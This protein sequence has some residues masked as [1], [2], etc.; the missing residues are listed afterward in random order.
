MNRIRIVIAL[1]VITL[2]SSV[3]AAG[4]RVHAQTPA[5]ITPATVQATATTLTLTPLG[6]AMINSNAPATNFGGQAEL[7]V[8]KVGNTLQPEARSLLRFDLTAIPAGSTIQRA[9]LRLHQIR[10]TGGNWTM[11]LARVSADWNANTVTW[12]TR[13]PVGAF[14]DYTFDAPPGDDIVLTVDVTNLVE[15][16]VYTPGSMPN[17]GFELSG[18]T[19]IGAS[20]T[21]A[22]ASMEGK[23]KPELVIDYSAPPPAVTILE[24]TTPVK[25]DANCLREEYTNAATLNYVDAFAQVSTIFLKHDAANIYVCIQG[26]AGRSA[27]RFFGVYLD[28]DFGREEYA[29]PEDLAL[30]VGITTNAL[31]SYQ[32]TG[33]QDI[34]YTPVELPLGAWEAT[35]MST[36]ADVAEYRIARSLIAPG[37]SNPFGLAVYHQRVND[38]SDDYGLPPGQQAFNTP[39]AW[40]QATLQNPRCVRVCVETSVPCVPA[41]SATV[42][43]T[44]NGAAFSLDSNG[45]VIGGQQLANGDSL[46]A[47]LPI[48]SGAN[49]TLYHTSGEPVLVSAEAF[50][51]STAGTLTLVVTRQKPL[52]V[53]DL[54]VSAEWYV[55]G[56]P[57]RE[58]W[59]REN[60]IKAANYFYAFT[61]GQFA[62][63]QITVH[64]SL[65]AWQAADLRLHINNVL[66]P[67]AIIG[68]IVPTTTID[69]W[70]VVSYTYSPGHFFMGSHWN[71]YGAPPN[72]PIK[73]NGEPVPPA[74]MADDWALAMAHE[75]G[76][77]LLFLFD[78]YTDV[79]GNASQ[80]LAAL[81]TGSAM[82]DVYK[83]GNQNY[84]YNLSHWNA[85]C[86][87]TEA[88]NKL[89]GRSEWQTIQAWYPWAIQP[90]GF[91]TGP[92]AP[93]INLTTVNF[94][95]PSTAP[96][97]L[98]TS[99]VFD[100]LYQAGELTSGEARV[101]TLRG[102]RVY[103]QGKPAK[104]DTQVTLIDAQVADRLCVYDVNDQAEAGDAPRHQFGCEIIQLNDAELMMTK[105]PT[106]EPLIKLTQ[107]GPNQV[108]LVVTNP[109]T[110]PVGAQVMARL[111]PEH[112]LGY[113]PLALTGSDGVYSGVFDLPEP[114]P[115]LYAQLWVEETPAGL[116]TRREVMADRGTGG[117]GAFGPATRFGGVLVVSSD[118]NA[119]YER[120]Q[121]LDLGLGQSI[122]WQSMPG[123][124][125]LPSGNQIIGQSYRLDAYPPSL[126][127]S[128]KVHIQYRELTGLAQAAGIKQ[129]RAGDPTVYF[130][131][132][133]VWRPLGTIIS[134]PTNAADGVQLA[135]AQSQGVGVYIVMVDPGQH[136]IFLPVVQRK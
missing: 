8:S 133:N 23:I 94:V 100:L 1:L 68:G 32:G 64:Q 131:D 2:V 33:N 83:P 21:R 118:G 19:V 116:A 70:A 97:T 135:T 128:G 29:E 115:P 10:A 53:Y 36:N 42:F 4:T 12:N 120:D 123:T 15:R 109:L 35:A 39:V 16:W 89:K 65:D 134:T 88:H 114:V 105:N 78:T 67:K 104:N 17:Y 111:Y 84:I 61:D 48:T 20:L 63:G 79:D 125:P 30:Q 47:T 73:D 54:D 18:V 13:P 52:L 34:V 25:I 41:P 28:T 127:A 66:Q 44:I 98:A 117:S 71:R 129:N 106:W 110:T 27:Q 121:S 7:M 22:F 11:N 6:D 122:A 77:Y 80:E 136:Q 103:E 72:E 26:V 85:A 59:L 108:S 96:G 74:T 57:Q 31:A 5:D 92:V 75:L 56:D 38:I 82:G 95:D 101:F 132:G 55:Q 87:G 40:L 45:Y 49:S 90:T 3:L 62:L 37:C 124:P 50:N 43:K 60:I 93:P 81:C 14:P 9:T 91:V 51:G 46:W 126:V 107:T 58:A 130:W 69:P 86:S 24:D 112:G 102:D 99:Q 113:P 76:H 119:S